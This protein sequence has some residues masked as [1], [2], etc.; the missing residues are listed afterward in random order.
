M[1]MTKSKWVKLVLGCYEDR[2]DKIQN[3]NSLTISTRRSLLNLS[4]KA[5][6]RRI[7]LL[8]LSFSMAIFFSS[9]E[10]CLPTE[11]KILS[12]TKKKC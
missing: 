10:S 8:I 2:D 12:V 6:S 1:E 11:N 5:E 4:K 9:S 3:S 7:I